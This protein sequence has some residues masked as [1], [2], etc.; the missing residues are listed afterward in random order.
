MASIGNAAAA[1]VAVDW[2]GA[3]ISASGWAIILL[4]ITIVV[5]LAVIFTRGDIA[6]SLVIVWALA[7]ISVKHSAVQSIVVAAGIGIA[8]VLGAL[9][10]KVLKDRRFRS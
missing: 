2:A 5:T 10:V 9:A 7:G 8:I 6:Y 3:G 1:L 4:S